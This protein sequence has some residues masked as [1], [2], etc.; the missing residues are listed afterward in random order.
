MTLLLFSQDSVVTSQGEGGLSDTLFR[1]L[2]TKVC[3]LTTC[4]KLS[5]LLKVSQCNYLIYILIFLIIK[6]CR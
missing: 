4:C 2:K 6:L 1:D 5:M 3:D